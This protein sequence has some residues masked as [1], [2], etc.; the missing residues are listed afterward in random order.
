MLTSISFLFL[1]ISYSLHILAP[2]TCSSGF[3]CLLLIRLIGKTSASVIIEQAA[4]ED[5]ATQLVLDSVWY[6]QYQ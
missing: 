2:L 1:F 5:F 3:S 4:Q 6:H